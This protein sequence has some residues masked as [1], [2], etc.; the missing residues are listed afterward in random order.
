MGPSHGGI[1]SGGDLASGCQNGA[2]GMGVT[3]GAGRLASL[4]AR[5]GSLLVRT[6]KEKSG[7]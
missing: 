1:A 4:P 2:A 5:S 7:L 3:V 6:C